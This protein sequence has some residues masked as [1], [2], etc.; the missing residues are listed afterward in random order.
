[1]IIL[2]AI[3][4]EGHGAGGP[5]ITALLYW[6][7]GQAL[8]YVTAIVY[9]LITPYNIHEHI[10][11]GN[12]AV[13]IG[14]AGALIAIANLIRFALMHDFEDWTTTLTDVGIDVGIGLAF[15]PIA[16]FLTDKILLPGQNLTDEIVNQE[17]PNNGAALVEAF[18]YIGGSVLITW[19]L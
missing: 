14:F 6:A 15:L 3:H 19:S 5:I 12:I 13:G 7:L 2:G 4:G 10:E 8:M 9:N 16:R 11:K 17:H 1:L 18:A